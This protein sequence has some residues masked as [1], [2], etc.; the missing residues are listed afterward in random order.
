MANKNAIYGARAVKSLLGMKFSSKVTS[1]TVLASDS[2]A[3]WVGDFV[4]LTGTAAEGPDGI[5]RQVITRAAAGNTLVGFVDSFEVDANYLN[6]VY[7]TAS[8]LR[9]AHV[10]DDPY[11]LFEA[12]AQGT[13][14][15]GDIG[16]N[17]DIAVSNGS[18]VTGLSG[19]EINLATKTTASAQVRIMS[20]SP[21]ADN[22]YGANADV[23]CMINEHAYK[24]TL[25][26]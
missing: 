2:T 13:L 7:R 1:Y 21:R 3:M 18:S 16:L 14:A 22:E 19:S 10:Y 8:T 6:Q 5:S 24:G 12:Q 15:P 20:I 17:A 26:V 25:G 11:V 4:K 23:V 9:T